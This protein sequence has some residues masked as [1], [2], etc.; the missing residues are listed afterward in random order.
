MHRSL[1]NHLLMFTHFLST[2]HSALRWDAKVYN[3]AGAPVEYLIQL[4]SRRR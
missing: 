4:E 3:T 1:L 2:L